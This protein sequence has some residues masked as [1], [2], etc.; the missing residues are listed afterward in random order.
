MI[1]LQ[2]GMLNRQYIAQEIGE[3]GF[4]TLSLLGGVGQMSMT[5]LGNMPVP[6]FAKLYTVSLPLLTACLHLLPYRLPVQ[7]NA[8]RSVVSSEAVFV[9]CKDA[10]HS[11]R[12]W[13]ACT[14]WLLKHKEGVMTIIKME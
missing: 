11:K 6:D 12:K 7:P 14:V 4:I 3:S 5:D 1:C 10:M 13:I 9:L 8:T 2:L